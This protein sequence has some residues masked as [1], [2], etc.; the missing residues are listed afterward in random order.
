MSAVTAAA[1]AVA[2]VAVG[3]GLWQ[4]GVSHAAVDQATKGARNVVVTT[5]DIAA[6]EPFGADA[7]R[8]AEVP[9]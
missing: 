7:V 8:L 3:Y 2:F 4:A 1:V 9:Q 5:R 6:G